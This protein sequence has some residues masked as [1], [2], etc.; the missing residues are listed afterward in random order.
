MNN[1]E[2]K[3]AI[4]EAAKEPLRILVLAILPVFIAYF[5]VLPYQWAVIATLIL[6]TID[7]FMHNYELEKPVK[8]QNEGFLGVHGLTGF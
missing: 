4:I 5:A 7:S 2:F 1:D 6:R 3:K 8:L